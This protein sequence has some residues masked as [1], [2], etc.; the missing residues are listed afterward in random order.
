MDKVLEDIETAAAFIAYFHGRI[1]PN[2]QTVPSDTY[3]FLPTE[4]AELCNAKFDRLVFDTF[5][6]EHRDKVIKSLEGTYS[7]RI[8]DNLTLYLPGDRYYDRALYYDS[9]KNMIAGIFYTDEIYPTSF[10]Q[11]LFYSNV[12]SNTSINLSDILQLISTEYKNVPKILVL[13]SCSSIIN[14]GL[15]V[16]TVEKIMRNE[17]QQKL[18]MLELRTKSAPTNVYENAMNDKSGSFVAP[19]SLV[20]GKE[21]FINIPARQGPYNPPPPNYVSLLYTRENGSQYT[22]RNTEG[23]HLFPRN[24]LAEIIAASG[25]P[26]AAFSVITPSRANRS[27]ASIVPYV[28]S[29]SGGT[30]RK[31]MVLMRRH[32][33]KQKSRCKRK[34]KSASFSHR[35]R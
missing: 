33:C 6:S 20:I 1:T 34:R 17:R 9:N 14:Q 28:A 12:S 18:R 23:R 19:E 27:G 5:K 2:V 31:K 35:T 15:F 24:Q 13:V 4:V 10:S 30:R 32:T 11:T 22:Y 7:S 25:I 26:P 8:L 29:G 16:S 21:K 3:L